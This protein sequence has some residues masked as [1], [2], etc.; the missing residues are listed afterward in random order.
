[1]SVFGDNLLDQPHH[2]GSAL[3]L[4]R[5]AAGLDEDVPVL[6]RVPRSRP[7]RAVH[8]RS[9]QDGEPRYH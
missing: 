1:M 8:V 2:D 5:Q 4:P 6:V 9:V 3:H 7:V